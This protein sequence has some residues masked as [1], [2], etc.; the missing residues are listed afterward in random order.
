MAR[1]KYQIGERVEMLCDHERDGRR[2]IDWLPG[3]V[4]E[5]DPRM[6][7]VRFGAPVYASN[8]W[9]IPDQVLWCTHG[10]R[11]IRRLGEDGPG[12]RDEEGKQT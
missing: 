10:S 1:A 11:H 7:A 5:A 12:P 6:L 8:G 9:R 2:V 3:E 4:I